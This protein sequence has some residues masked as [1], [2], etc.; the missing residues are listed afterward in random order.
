MPK[1]TAAQAKGITKVE[2]ELGRPGF[3]PL[4]TGRYVG[5]LSDVTAKMSKNNNPIWNVEWDNIRGLD[6]EEFGGRQFYTLNFPT[7]AKR[8]AGWGEDNA[9]S[10]KK[11]PDE[12]WADYQTSCKARLH[13]F[14]TAHGYTTDTDTDEM[15]NDEAECILE[16][17][18]ET[19]REGARAGQLRNV[20]NGFL[21]L[22]EETA[23]AAASEDDED[24]DEF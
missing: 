11:S 16:I 1:L 17:G 22:D 2:P 23:A 7:S 12:R 21:P 14:F 4:P 5:R 10:K 20:I 9:A 18:Q 3:E 19:Q 15:I 13:G 6:G 24:D 8:P